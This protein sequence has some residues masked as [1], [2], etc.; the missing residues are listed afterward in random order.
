M[1]SLGHVDRCAAHTDDAHDL[2]TEDHRKSEIWVK[3]NV[4]IVFLNFFS[5]SPGHSGGAL[6]V[7]RR[8]EG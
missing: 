6:P 7:T 1:G 2:R 5:E 8:R 4:T 3:R